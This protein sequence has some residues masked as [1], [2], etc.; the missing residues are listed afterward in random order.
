MVNFMIDGGCIS[1]R[2]LQLEARLGIT[3]AKSPTD[4]KPEL[5]VQPQAQP[6]PPSQPTDDGKRKS[7]RRKE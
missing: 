2:R 5:P 1:S 3:L 6:A 4:T 7:A